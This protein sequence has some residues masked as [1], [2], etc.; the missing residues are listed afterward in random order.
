MVLK[1]LRGLDPP[2]PDRTVG[3]DCPAWVPT[4][5]PPPPHI[6]ETE[7]PPATATATLSVR[8]CERKAEACEP[9]SRAQTR[10]MS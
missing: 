5:P 1:T 7:V 10:T 2:P 6:S 9:R 8:R 3:F 4:A